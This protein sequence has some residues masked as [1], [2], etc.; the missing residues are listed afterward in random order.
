[1]AYWMWCYLGHRRWLVQWI[2]ECIGSSSPLHQIGRPPLGVGHP[3]SDSA[4]GPHPYRRKLRYKRRVSMTTSILMDISENS[5][6][7]CTLLYSGGLFNLILVYQTGELVSCRQTP[8][9]LSSHNAPLQRW[10]QFWGPQWHYQRTWS[11]TT[12]SHGR[13]EPIQHQ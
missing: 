5:K 11:L 8:Q 1:M 4:P 12:E 2:E 6:G 13:E 9:P 3:A 7:R 10:R